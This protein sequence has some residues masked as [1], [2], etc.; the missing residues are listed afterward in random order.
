MSEVKQGMD[1]QQV[2]ADSQDKLKNIRV[3]RDLPVTAT[4][5]NVVFG[6]V[7]VGLVLM[8]G[9]FVFQIVA[10]MFAIM[11][12]VVFG[13]VSLLAIRHM[14][15]LDPLIAQKVKNYVLEQQMKEAQENNIIQLQQIVL[16]RKNQLDAGLTARAEMGGH[17]NKLKMN[18]DKSDTGNSFYVQKQDMYLKVEKAF[19]HNKVML[20]NATDSL[21]EFEA[22]VYHYKDMA[23]F[24]KIAG[25]AMAALDN[26]HLDDMLSLEAFGTI[27]TEFCT[28][29]SQIDTTI[30]FA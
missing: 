18:L 27:E 21:K 11:T 19:A 8:A 10:G 12:A 29:M 3:S 26:N 2:L 25:K 14:R 24:S 9:M 16:S 6:G 30:E 17:L 1:F 28:A 5:R 22:K 13:G 7:G 20:Q 15:K 4:A 23:E